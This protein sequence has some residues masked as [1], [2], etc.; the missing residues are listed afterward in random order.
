V[1]GV[2][3]AAEPATEVSTG[4]LSVPVESLVS[5]ESPVIVESAVSDR[6]GC[7]EYQEYPGEAWGG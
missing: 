1:A 6:N 5:D 7:K 4:C 3:C 2:V